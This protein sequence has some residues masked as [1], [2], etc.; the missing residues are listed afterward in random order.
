MA[1]RH[2]LW[3][4]LGG[5]AP[6][7]S[8]G[9]WPLRARA[10]GSSRPPRR[11]RL[12]RRQAPA[13][14]AGAAASDAAGQKAA[15]AAIP[16]AAATYIGDTACIDCHDDQKKSYLNTMH[17]RPDH[18]RSPAAASGCESCHG[19]G[20]DPRRRPDRS[21]ARSGCSRRCRRARSATTCMT[22]HNRQTHALWDGS[23]HDARNLSCVTC[24]SVHSF[25][26]EQAQLKHADRDGHVRDLPSRQGR[27]ARS[28][29]PHAG[30]RRQDAVLDLPQPARLDQRQAAAAG[31]LDR[32]DLH[33]VP[34]RQ[35]R[36]VSLGARA[37]PRR[38]HDLPRS[39]RL[40][41]RAHAGREAADPLP[42]L[43][44]RHAASRARSTTAR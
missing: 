18:P 33:V 23:A 30:A 7:R 6:D 44:R 32:R 27:Q 42:A 10:T 17:G 1:D 25:K 38:L 24:H 20:V 5:P 29:G 31:R 4:S 22:C 39:A 34:R 8:R 11:S 26:S 2:R 19:P 21:P 28:L 9:A 36:A 15:A 14:T 41:E 3:V 13:S 43:P 12:R 37:G 40:V 16:A 35:A